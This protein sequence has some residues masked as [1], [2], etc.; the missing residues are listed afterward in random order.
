MKNKILPFLLVI[1]LITPFL[2]AAQSTSNNPCTGNGDLG[3]CIS[4]IYIWSLGISGLIAVVMCVFGGYLVMTAR[5]NG[6]QASNGRSYITSSITG[7][8]L[9]LA[10]Y[11]LLNTI[12]PDLTNFNVPDFMNV[13]PTPAP[14]PTPTPPRQ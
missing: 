7:M 8:V 12:N 14:S 10:A 11:L 9:L 2:V 3:Q 4:R 13:S 6:Q 5:G 1:L